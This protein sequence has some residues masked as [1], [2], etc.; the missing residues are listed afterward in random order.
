MSSAS[1][2]AMKVFPDWETPAS[3]LMS[4]SENHSLTSQECSGPGSSSS[5]S[6]MAPNFDRT[7]S[8]KIQET[9][10]RKSSPVSIPVGCSHRCL[11]ICANYDDCSFAL[12]ELPTGSFQGH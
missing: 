8:S 3:T 1:S 4:L 10:L 6:L 2:K 9:R 12:N 11:V 7:P 5:S